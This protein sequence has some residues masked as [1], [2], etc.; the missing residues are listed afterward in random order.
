MKF[1]LPLIMTTGLKKIYLR[2]PTEE[3]AIKFLENIYWEGQAVCPYC[4][5][6]AVTPYINEHRYHC[7]VCLCSFS[8]TVNSLF[9]KTKVPVQKWLYVIMMLSSGQKV[10]PF[11]MIAEEIEVTKDTVQ[12]MVN[13][14]RNSDI[15]NQHIL[16]KIINQLSNAKET[17]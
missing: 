4:K 14:L 10:P 9:H 15:A 2:F 13:K 6:T 16:A 5:S 11:R 8:V 17:P 3:S 1:A 7:N 12:K